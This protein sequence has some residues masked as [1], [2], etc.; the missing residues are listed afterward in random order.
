MQEIRIAQPDATI[1]P[2][3]D[4]RTH[5]LWSGVRQALL[6]LVDTIERYLDV[7]PRTAELRKEKR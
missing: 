3:L 4:S 2:T 7:S 1:T 6:M 5:A